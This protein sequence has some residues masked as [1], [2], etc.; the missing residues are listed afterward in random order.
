M[1]K[2]NPDTTKTEIGGKVFEA[3]WVNR[4]KGGV[5]WRLAINGKSVKKA[6]YDSEMEKAKGISKGG[7][8]DEPHTTAAAEVV[9]RA[10][11]EKSSATYRNPSIGVDWEP[12]TGHATATIEALERAGYRIVKDQ[13]HD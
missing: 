4:P 2:P 13:S 5:G 7:S 9:A 10:L 1:D 8:E 11:A 3:G 12:W 6:V